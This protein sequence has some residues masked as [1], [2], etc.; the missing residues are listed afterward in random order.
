[1]YEGSFFRARQSRSGLSLALRESAR[2]PRMGTIHASA[3]AYRRA[4]QLGL[5]ML[6][7]ALGLLA[8]SAPAQALPDR[9][10]L[11]PEA[12][13][14]PLGSTHT[15][16]ATV[17]EAGAPVADVHVDF[18]SSFGIFNIACQES[19][20]FQVTTDANGKA[21]CTYS[22][23][24]AGTE[25][26]TAFA[27]TNNNNSQDVGEPSD[28]ATKRWRSAPATSLTLEP[29]R[30]ARILAT[31]GCVTARATNG[32][33]PAGDQT[34]SFTVTGAN[35]KSEALTTNTNGEVTFCY[36]GENGGLDA[37]TAF[38]DSNENKTKDESEP[39]DTA[40]KRWLSNPSITLAP[41]TAENP[42][43]S[44]HTLTATVT[45][46]GAPVA[47]VHVDFFSS[48]GIFNIACQESGSFQ[49]TTDANGKAN[50]TYSGNFAGTETITA[51]ADTNNNNS[52]D[53]G[54]PSDT[55]TKRWRSAPATSLTLEPKREARILATE[56]CVTARATNGTG[57]AGD[58]TVS[59]TVTGAN[60]KSEAL[61]T[62][63]NG[64]VTF[65]YK[66][67]NGGLDAITAFVDSNE[68][69]T[70]DESEPQDTATKRWLSNPSITL[71]PK[72]AENPLGS[73]HTLTATVTEAGAPVADVNNVLDGGEASDSATKRWVSQPPAFLTLELVTGEQHNNPN[74][75]TV[76]GTELC[77]NA[78][79]TDA[80]KHPTAERIVRF[81][82]TGANPTAQPTAV[83]TNSGG[84]A[85]FCYKGANAGTDTIKAF[86]DT[87]ENGTQDPSSPAEPGEQQTH[88]Y[89]AAPPSTLTVSPKAATN[90]VGT[91]HTLTATV[92]DAGKPVPNVPVVFDFSQTGNVFGVCE[93]KAFNN[94]KTSDANGQA[95]CTYTSPDARSDTI[96]VFADTNVN[97]VLDG[98][99]ASDSA[100][101]RWV[102]QPPA[103][104]TL[105]LVTG[106]Q[107]NNP[108]F[109][110][111]IGTELCANAV[112][113]DAEK[114]P[115]AERV[116]RFSV[117]GAN[118]TAQPIAVTTNSGGF[119][120]FCY[121]GANA[122]TDT[123]KAF[124]DTNENGTQD[125]LPLPAEPGEQQ[126]HTYL[127]APPSTLT[128]SPKAATNTV[129]TNHTLTATVT[130]AGKPVPNVPVV[131]DFSQTGN[132]FGVCEGKAFNN[133]KTSDANGQASC[134]Y[135]S[136]DARSDTITVFADTNVN[137]VLDGGE[138]SDSAT[139]RWVR[140]DVPAS[141]ELNPE[142]ATNLINTE[143]CL[144]ALVKDSTGAPT[145]G[146]QVRFV[147]TG[148]NTTD[149]G[150]ATGSDG[151]AGRCYKAPTP[152]PTR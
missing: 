42:L 120:Q 40:T 131:F 62:N 25:T 136:P 61:T 5:A 68:N 32:T 134:T 113:T 47:D 16:T 12:A 129:G 4:F 118:P 10:T 50:C 128:V 135:T 100:T 85:Q 20:S 141:L 65:C 56:G 37:I 72:T 36:K 133:V 87:N 140:A 119:A 139:K 99:E 108:N 97:N 54:E 74:F 143:H 101:K 150:S 29:K 127:A 98:G 34:V 59:F 103:F 8:F 121:K 152:A 71:A 125:P 114:H 147:V 94:V 81:S 55:A 44:T 60:Q 73:T 93:G 41:K 49:V 126:T 124:A 51:F 106:E 91:N 149:V 46:A 89:L 77:A 137:N 90:T 6:V 43:G 19:G 14:N 24:F 17:T 80:E 3:P 35:Q 57:P 76:I 112:V 84:F 11:T 26:I 95:S 102:S 86:A 13:E 23:N 66:G 58:Q 69:K 92:T 38:V 48:F 28:T 79:V 78:V 2:V 33:G 64:E 67:E 1:M 27:D 123:I 22:G 145:G 15:L 142:T 146:W 107:H 132:V 18:F 88:T 117:T 30:E 148:A 39:Q 122:G 70:K 83:T 96:T 63:T 130:D 151:R 109:A 116:V 110:T 45:E 9:L 82:V 144:T 105:E 138:A 111:V 115:T 21:N 7:A 104:L 75:A 52:Q 31:E 53:V